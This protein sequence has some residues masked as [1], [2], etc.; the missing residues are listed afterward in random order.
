MIPDVRTKLKERKQRNKR[1]WDV[2]GKSLPKLTYGQTV[3]VK[4]K[5]QLKH[6]SWIPATV[7]DKVAPRSYDVEIPNKGIVRRNRTDIRETLEWRIVDGQLPEV[8]SNEV[9]VH[10]A[11]QD[12]FET[13]YSELS[14]HSRCSRHEDQV[15]GSKDNKIWKNRR[16]YSEIH[17]IIGCGFIVVTVKLYVI[18]FFYLYF[19]SVNWE[20]DCTI[21]YKQ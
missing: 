14:G 8:S 5:P 11:P 6:D 12:N 18:S 10:K 13:S 15:L 17:T 19:I 9:D 21:S 16:D 1:L 20:R 2:N 4:S 7:L 3:C